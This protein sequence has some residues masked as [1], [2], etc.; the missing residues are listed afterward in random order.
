MA[1]NFFETPLDTSFYEVPLTKKKI[2]D[3]KLEVEVAAII[4]VN[5]IFFV[6]ITE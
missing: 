2:R 4:E 3:L 5:H 6:L 1:P